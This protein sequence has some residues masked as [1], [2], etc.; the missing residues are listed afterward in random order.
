MSYAHA[1]EADERYGK[2][3]DDAIRS[4]RA[5]ERVIFRIRNS[6][7]RR[8]L[9]TREVVRRRHLAAS[10]AII[11]RSFLLCASHWSGTSP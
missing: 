8:Q 7:R 2:R 1:N 3:I 11:P 4:D 10:A 6:D 9:V 5:E